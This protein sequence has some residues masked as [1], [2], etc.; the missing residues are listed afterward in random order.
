[1]TDVF[2]MHPNILN[3][4]TF[5]IDR[6]NCQ[7]RCKC[8]GFRIT[9]QEKNKQHCHFLHFFSLASVGGGNKYVI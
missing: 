4:I 5:C 9:D 2:I 8:M 6:G 7:M 1:M 3:T